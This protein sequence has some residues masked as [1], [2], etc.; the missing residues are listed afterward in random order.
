MNTPIDQ[1]AR[2]LRAFAALAAVA[3]ALGL[4]VAAQARP[5]PWCAFTGSYQGSFDC[6]YYTLE[7]CM[8]TARGL[9]NFCTPNPA[10]GDIRDRKRR[11]SREW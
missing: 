10:V 2:A 11:R 7:Q 6:S 1:A 3:I 5:A 9:G 8:Q 4:P